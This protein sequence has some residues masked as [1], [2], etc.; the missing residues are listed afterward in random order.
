MCTCVREVCK[1]GYVSVCACV[2]VCVCVW[3]R[4]REREREHS[5]LLPAKSTTT[6]VSPASSTAPMYSFLNTWLPLATRVSTAKI[7][8]WEVLAKYRVLTMFPRR[9]ARN[10]MLDHMIGKERRNTESTFCIL[11]GQCIHGTLWWEEKRICVWTLRPWLLRYLKETKKNIL[12]VA[13]PLGTLSLLTWVDWLS[14]SGS[15][16]FWLIGCNIWTRTL[17]HF[18]PT[19][20]VA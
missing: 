12:Y 16:F 17:L 5:Q 15:H 1:L 9:I 7:F 2:C 13:P 4:E 8:V 6:Q 18:L 19:L 14:L 3:E 11:K 10:W 20:W